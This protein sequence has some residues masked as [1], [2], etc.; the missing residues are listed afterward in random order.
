[1]VNLWDICKSQAKMGHYGKTYNLNE[2]SAYD[3]SSIIDRRKIQD[4][5]SQNWISFQE[6]TK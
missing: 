4:D 2:I 3:S 6:M 1:M 5:S